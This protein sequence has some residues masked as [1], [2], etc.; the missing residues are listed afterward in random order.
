V[1][2]YTPQHHVTALES[3]TPLL[4]VYHSL[5]NITYLLTRFYITCTHVHMYTCMSCRYSVDSVRLPGPIDG[6]DEGSEL[7]VCFE[8]GGKMASSLDQTPEFEEPGSGRVSECG[9]GSGSGSGRVSECG[10]GSGSGRVSECG[11]G[12]GRVSKCGSGSG[13]VIRFHNQELRLVVTLYQQNDKKMIGKVKFQ[14]KRGSLVVR[15]KCVGGGRAAVQFKG[16]GVV[17]LDLAAIAEATASGIVIGAQSREEVL[18]KCTVSGAVIVFRVEASL[19]DKEVTFGDENE[20]VDENFGTCVEG[21][22]CVVVCCTTLYCTVLCINL[23][24]KL[25]DNINIVSSV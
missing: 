5:N 23:D 17:Q 16:V 10:S 25:L 18:Q 22:Y 8:R 7:S 19:L 14:E 9:S 15:R 21:L 6:V 20:E 11:S 12:S 3:F 4:Y 13:C 2:E 24:I 1:S